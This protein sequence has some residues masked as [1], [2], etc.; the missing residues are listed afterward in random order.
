MN[1]LHKSLLAN[2]ANKYKVK[3]KLV[4]GLTENFFENLFKTLEKYPDVKIEGLGRFKIHK[5]EH[6]IQKERTKPRRKKDDTSEF[7][8]ICLDQYREL[9]YASGEFV[10]VQRRRRN[11]AKERQDDFLKSFGS[12]PLLLNE[13]LNMNK[14]YYLSAHQRGKDYAIEKQFFTDKK[15]AMEESKN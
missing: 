3:L 11:E 5:I 1:P 12:V 9:L 15:I 8:R 7:Q 14:V 4:E 10:K 2:I 13:G 6:K